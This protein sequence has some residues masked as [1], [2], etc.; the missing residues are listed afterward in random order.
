MDINIIH[1]TLNYKQS[2]LCNNTASEK[3]C[4]VICELEFHFGQTFDKFI[5]A[6]AII[7]DNIVIVS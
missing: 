3:G 6:G 4:T 5:I 1:N 7:I 2:F